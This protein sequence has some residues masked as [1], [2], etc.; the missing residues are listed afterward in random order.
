METTVRT[1]FDEQNDKAGQQDPTRSRAAISPHKTGNERM[2][3]AKDPEETSMSHHQADP[4]PRGTPFILPP[5][6]GRESVHK[7]PGGAM[8]NLMEFCVN[9][10]TWQ[11]MNRI[12][13]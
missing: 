2:T 6:V 5:E 8:A 12:R 1:S 4:D 9:G 10:A 11:K 3:K 13:A 7:H